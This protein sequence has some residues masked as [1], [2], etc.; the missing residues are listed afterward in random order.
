MSKSR[1]EIGGNVV[2]FSTEIPISQSMSVSDIREPFKAQSSRTLT[3]FIDGTSEI[4]RVFENIFEVNSQRNNFNPNLKTETKYFVNDILVFQGFIQ[5]LKIN[6]TIQ[7]NELTCNYECSMIGDEGSIFLKIAGLYLTD[8]D[9]SDLDHNL[10]ITFPVTS[11]PKFNPPFAGTGY[12][13]PYIDYG[14][15]DYVAGQPLSSLWRLEYLKPAIFEQEYVR[16]IFENQGYKLG[17]SNN[18]FLQSH[19]GLIVIPCCEAGRL[20]LSPAIKAT[21]AFKAGMVTNAVY[22]TSGSTGAVVSTYSPSAI[23]PI[24]FDDVTTSPYFN[25]SVPATTGFDT[26]NNR[27]VIPLAAYYDGKCTCNFELTVSPRSGTTAFTGGFVGEVVI[28]GST[29]SGS[30][31]VPINSATFSILVSGLGA[32]TAVFYGGVEVT[33]ANVLSVPTTTML[34]AKIV[35]QV[36]TIAYSG[37]STATGSNVSLKVYGGA[38]SNASSFQ[39]FVNRADLAYGA[40]VVM[41]ET[42]PKNIT[43]IDFLTSIMQAEH[44]FLELDKSDKVTYTAYR[45]ED[46]YLPL[47]DAIDWTA[48]L[49][50]NSRIEIDPMGTLDFRRY[51]FTYK[52]DYDHYNKLY[53]DTYK[54]VYGTKIY[55]VENDFLRD[56]K[57][58]EL[59][60]SA[61]PVTSW[62]NGGVI[63]PRFFTFENVAGV[64]TVK[65]IKVNIRRLRYS[66][67]TTQNVVNAF[68]ANGQS[69]LINQY[70]YAGDVSN[71]YVPAI[72]LN[73]GIPKTLFWNFS[74]AQY[75]TN[76]R[77]NECYSKWMSEI[78][79]PNSKV[80]TMK[81]YLTENDINKFTFRK[82]IFVIDAYYYVNRIV[83]YDPQNEGLTEVECLKLEAG[84]PF[85]G[86][87]TNIELYDPSGGSSASNR[88]SGG[89]FNIGNNNYNGGTDSLI[90]GSNNVIGEGASNVNLINCNNVIVSGFVENF[91]GVGLSNMEIDSTYSNSVK[92]K[93]NDRNTTQTGDFT[94]SEAY[95][96]YAVDATAGDIYVD[97]ALTG[98][99]IMIYKSD[100]TAS[101]V[102]ITPTGGFLVNGS[103]TKVLSTQYEK[104]TL[105]FTGTEWVY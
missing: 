16:R 25:S 97:L 100:S 74:G 38:G 98:E 23:T 59:V 13:Y 57:K 9:F 33:V 17:L 88:G 83:D 37:A 89:G 44:L 65:P 95:N 24:P 68:S 11:D 10:T 105:T 21:A 60:F 99:A 76:N 101:I 28:E 29:N 71:P 54:E 67:L 63:C 27:F 73:F 56:E 77:F 52:Q 75:T 72:D 96:T 15:N 47:S 87:T 78:I 94:T 12:V 20:Q 19:E 3:M 61:T 8:I 51:V 50:T 39:A 5:L 34:R 79:N 32:S 69:N 102:T 22:N 35:N 90:T 104:I 18:Y 1:L 36:A 30:T 84:L 46:Y 42:V 91:T 6:K 41:N 92:Y 48:K 26:A 93:N 4:N 81:F 45:R 49:D 2:S 31:W 43:Q 7:E 58:L 53:Y 66:L 55:D 62:N 80:V 14:V 64:Q 40:P 82:L 70:P 85:I 86:T 103:A